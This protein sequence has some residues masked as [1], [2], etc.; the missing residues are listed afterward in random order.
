MGGTYMLENQ[1]LLECKNIPANWYR[2]EV[3][4]RKYIPIIRL[5]EGGTNII[6]GNL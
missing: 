4:S 6:L 1:Y 5:Y 2:P 3:F